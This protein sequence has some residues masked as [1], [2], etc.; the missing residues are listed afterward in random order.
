MVKDCM[1]GIRDFDWFD[2]LFISSFG[3][4]VYFLINFFVNLIIKKKVVIIIMVVEVI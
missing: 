2:F 3:M 4:G 1:G